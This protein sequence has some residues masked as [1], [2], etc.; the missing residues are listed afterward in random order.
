M[1]DVMTRPSPKTLLLNPADNVAVALTTLDVGA[2]TPQGVKTLKRV[3]RG[4]KFAV[5]TV[6][7]GAPIVKFGQIIGF[8]RQAIAAGDWVHEHNLGV[9]E[10]HGAFERDY[11][12]GEGVVP[13]QFVKPEEQATF[14]GFRRANGKVGTRNYVGILTSVNCSATV[15]KFMAQEINRSGILDDYPTI[16]G[17]VPFIHGSGCALDDHGEGFEI[18]MRTEWGYAANPNL[19]AGCHRIPRPK[20]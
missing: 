13:T 3:P 15:A 7:A 2:E 17:I 18:L 4:H 6:A 5:K 19:G 9:G 16:D 20:V 1:S 8:A 12:F 11:A 14:E 10:S